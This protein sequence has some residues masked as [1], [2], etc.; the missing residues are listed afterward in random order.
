MLYDRLEEG[1]AAAEHLREV[2][3]RKEEEE[4]EEEEWKDTRGLGEWKSRREAAI[5]C[6]LEQ[7]LLWSAQL[8]YDSRTTQS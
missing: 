8:I 4:E 5:I 6:D 7:L 3:L 1:A 2:G